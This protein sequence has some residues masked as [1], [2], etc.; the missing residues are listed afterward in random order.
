M[1]ISGQ[2]PFQTE[3]RIEQSISGHRSIFHAI[4]DESPQRAFEAKRVH[5]QDVFQ[6]IESASATNATS[7]NAPQ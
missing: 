7:A 2:A 1:S 6:T 3:R 5:L 4:V